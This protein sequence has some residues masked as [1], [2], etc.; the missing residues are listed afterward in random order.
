[1]ATRKK[2]SL[3][4][5]FKEFIAL[6]N[7]EGVRY[8]LLGGYAVNYY[9]YHRFTGDIDFWIATDVDNARKVS[10][11]LQR[12]G[13][14]APAVKPETFIEPGKVHMFGVPPARVDLLTAPSGVTFDDCYARRVNI[15]LDGVPVPLI[16]LA[17]LRANKLAS[18][19]DKDQAD[20][21]RLP[22]P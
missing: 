7:S 12:F 22:H 9:G 1:M 11:A 18:G 20:L 5:D 19:R 6:L 21:K 3:N 17:D 4:P 14:S 16:S 13:F 2:I 8:L 10:A 15:S